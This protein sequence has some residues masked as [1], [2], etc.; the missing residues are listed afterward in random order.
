MDGGQ[1]QPQGAADA[2]QFV[3]MMRQLRQWAH[4]SYRE[5]ERR[6]EVA[7]D[8][9]PRATLASVLKR[10]ELPREELL[11]A[12]VR[13][14]GGDRSVVD[15]WVGVRKRLAVEA[16]QRASA[17]ESAAHAASGTPSPARIASAEACEPP[18]ARGE[19]QDGFPDGQDEAGSTGSLSAQAA[20]GAPRLDVNGCAKAPGL[21]SAAEAAAQEDSSMGTE[22]EADTG[23]AGE[24]EAVSQ[25]VLPTRPAQAPA[26]PAA[27][28]AEVRRSGHARRR[29]PVLVA[30]LVALLLSA[31]VTGIVLA[32]DDGPGEPSQPPKSPP[33]TVTLSPE[34]TSD[35]TPESTV[36]SPAAKPAAKDKPAPGTTR[37]TPSPTQKTSR[38]EQPVPEGTSRKPEST[39]YEPPPAPDDPYEPPPSSTPP[40]THGGDPFPEESCWDA[41]DDCV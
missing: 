13:A 21:P 35:R 12:F 41:T 15:A 19:T 6:A 14:C 4:L 39:P 33:V 10:Q 24:G 11:A 1:P 7:G 18:V 25:E 27:P 22:A 23:A 5:L 17:V 28:N 36:S 38:P 40:P 16:E 20:E 29:G 34:R 30:V 2:A 3:A 26:Q 9:L 31:G 37:H 32:P 8:V